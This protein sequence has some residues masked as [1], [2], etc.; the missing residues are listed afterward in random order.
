MFTFDQVYSYIVL[1][2]LQ[3]SAFVMLTVARNTPD[4]VITAWNFCKEFPF[5]AYDFWYLLNARNFSIVFL[6]TFCFHLV[7]EQFEIRE[8]LA[9][10]L[11]KLRR[12][13]KRSLISTLVF[14]LPDFGDR[15]FYS[16]GIILCFVLREQDFIVGLAQGVCLTAFLH[17]FRIQLLQSPTTSFAVTKTIPVILPKSG[18]VQEMA[19]KAKIYKSDT[20]LKSVIGIVQILPNGQV[21]QIGCA[22]YTNFSGTMLASTAK[23]VLAETMD[24]GLMYNHKLVKISTE[25]INHSFYSDRSFIMI[26]PTTAATLGIRAINPYVLKTTGEVTCHYY[27]AATHE[28]WYSTGLIHSNIEGTHEFKADY[29][30]TSGWSGCAIIQ[31]GSHVGIHGGGLVDYSLNYFNSLFGHVDILSNRNRE[32]ESTLLTKDKNDYED[33]EYMHRSDIMETLRYGRN[34]NPKLYD[35][36]GFRDFQEDYKDYT[37]KFGEDR[38]IADMEV[39]LDDVLQQGFRMKSKQYKAVVNEYREKFRVKSM[40]TKEARLSGLPFYFEEETKPLAS[41]ELPPLKVGGVSAPIRKTE[42]ASV[43]LNPL[44]TRQNALPLTETLPLTQSVEM[45][46]ETLVTKI[47]KKPSQAPLPLPRSS[48]PVSPQEKPSKSAIRRMKLKVK[49]LES[50]TTKASPTVILQESA[51]SQPI[52]PPQTSSQP[53]VTLQMLFTLLEKQS[54]DIAT[55]QSRLPAQ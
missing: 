27:D 24:Y 28:G 37:S 26:T 52:P 31:N 19:S 46:K 2:L 41:D 22:T 33:D 39:D 50:L 42:K 53:E 55:L 44:K 29:S 34:M 10:N 43:L 23:H 20:P 8:K 54:H 1:P 12:S 13:F 5:V 4:F 38:L 49:I 25:I 14:I 9:V 47:L 15:A 35:T 48:P 51:S 30:S 11:K 18:A 17:S 32:L 16:S 45:K 21:R 6:L 7:M 40:K 3:L 36:E